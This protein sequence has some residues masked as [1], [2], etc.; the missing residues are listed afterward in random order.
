MNMFFRKHVSL[1]TQHPSISA[2]VHMAM[3]LVHH[4]SFLSL[5][6][7]MEKF[8]SQELKG[9]AVADQFARGRTKIAAIEIVLGAL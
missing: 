7:H 5:S 4:S 1:H 9:S 8:I 6:D 3:L 2:E